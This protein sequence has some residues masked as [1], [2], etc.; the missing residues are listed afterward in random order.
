M[1]SSCKEWVTEP[2]ASEGEPDIPAIKAVMTDKILPEI[3]YGASPVTAKVSSMEPAR[4]SVAIEGVPGDTVIEAV[5]AVSLMTHHL[6][7]IP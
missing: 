3:A 2:S 4:V 7:V 1:A 5:K 6:L